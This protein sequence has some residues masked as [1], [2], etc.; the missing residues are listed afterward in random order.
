VPLPVI[1]ADGRYPGDYEVTLNATEFEFN[2]WEFGTWDPTINGFVPME[3]LGSRFIDG[4]LP[5]NKSCVRGFDN[6]GF[7]M[8]TSSSIFSAFIVQL[9]QTSLPEFAKTA[10]RNV[11]S[12]LAQNNETIAL[13]GPN[14]FYQYENNPWA[15]QQ[16]LDLTDGGLNGENIPL[17]SLIQPNRSVDVVFAVDASGDVNS[18]PDG[19]A[20]VRTYERSLNSTGIGENATAFPTIPGQ[21]TF[22]NLGLNTKPT[23]FGCN[24]SNLTGPAPLVVYL[25]NYPYI[26]YSNVSTFDLEYTTEQ[27]DAM[28][29]NGYDI[30]TMA[31]NSR[32][33]NWTTCAGCAVLG[34]SFERTDTP[35]PDACKSCFEKYCWDGTT[36]SSDHPPYTPNALLATVLTDSA[37]TIIPSLFTIMVAVGVALLNMA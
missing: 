37:G 3:Y 7:A 5:E 4:Q 14:P 24:T 12:E 25:P 26:T 33:A 2:P 31:N 28:L 20:L 34:R 11:L 18:W 35:L 16:T 1:V 13:Y 29:T 8:G 32:D 36:D 10:L 19:S 21:S 30:V 6:A 17:H 27:R 22:I 23:F 9:N 15:N